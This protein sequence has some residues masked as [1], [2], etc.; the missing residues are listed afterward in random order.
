MKWILLIII[1]LSS[2]NGFADVKLQPIFGDNMV[3]QRN[4]TANFWGTA[5]SGESIT[6]SGSWGD[7]AKTAADNNGKWKIKLKTP[8]AGGPFTVIIQGKNKITF[9]NVM[10]GEVWLCTGQSNMDCDMNFFKDTKEA[11][12]NANYPQ[13]RL[14]NVRKKTSNTPLKTLGGS[15]GICS[16]RT[17]KGFSATGYFFGLKLYKE[18]NIPIGLIECA[19]GG[20]RIEAWTPWE[21][22]KDNSRLVRER[23]NAAKQAKAYDEAKE[24]SIYNKTKEKYKTD[25]KDWNDGGK[26]GRRP[27][28][29]RFKQHPLKTANYSSNLYNGM[30][31]PLAPYTVKG[32]IWYQGEA[33][34]RRA[35]EYAGQLGIM[36]KSWRKK[37][38]Q[39]N[40]PFYSVQLPGFRKAWTTPVEEGPSRNWAFIRE[41]FA[42]AA[43][44]VPNSGMAITID[45]GEANDIHPQQ[46]SKVGERLAR[47]ALNKDYGRKDVVWTG[48]IMKSC[49]FKDSR[50]IISFETGG[51]PLAARNGEKIKGFA[52]YDSNSDMFVNANAKIVKNDMLEV[53]SKKVKTPTIVYYAWAQNPTGVNLIN[54]EGLPAS[55]F[56]YGKKPEFNLLKQCMP[57]VEKEYELVYEIDAKS[58]RCKSGTQFIYK[59]NNSAKVKGPF[60][61]LA[62]FLGLRDKAG[63]VKY[64]FVEM[65]PFTDDVKKIGVPDKVSGARFQCPVKNVKVKSNVPEVKTGNFPDACNIE[66]WDCNYSGTNA[67]KIPG[68]SNKFD[69]GD[70]I[71]ASVSPGYGSMQIHNNQEGQSIICF[72][73]F[74]AGR[75]ADVG[76]GNS[77]SSRAADWTFA[78]NA[79]TYSVAELKV[80]IK[81]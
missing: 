5:N 78:K 37:W 36:I 42:D 57:E 33:N 67:K 41:A 29:L 39:G 32:A 35:S 65:D 59:K 73:N 30:M 75:N 34:A 19:W 76:I 25:L 64:A 51:S 79:N 72:N 22:Q 12:A 58:A 81:K 70:I 3:L 62:Y 8:D 55:P 14:F 63:N 17:V 48:P 23:E 68:A 10:S 71:G 44:N 80:L 77:K 47:L 24:K 15:W 13:I 74:K 52:L 9:K 21:K 50:A 66:F 69:F 6:V 1:G 2:L 61:K 53:S 54:K 27:R 60:K 7:S 56:R 45:I 31:N 46:K 20:T 49:E 11:I 28:W 18:L 4:S 43:K 40:F 38:G 16:P 26:K